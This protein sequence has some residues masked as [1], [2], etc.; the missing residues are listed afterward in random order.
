[1]WSSH[2]PQL[3]NEV[4]VS[5]QMARKLLSC[6]HIEW[7]LSQLLPNKGVLHT[8]TCLRLSVWK[9]S[10]VPSRVFQ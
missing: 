9:I 5:I 4:L 8:P 2:H 3:A 6:S 7:N 10:G 1:M